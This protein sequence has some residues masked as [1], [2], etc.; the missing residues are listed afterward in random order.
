MLTG[1]PRSARIHA[2]VVDV[3]AAGVAQAAPLVAQLA[4]AADAELHAALEFGDDAS[5]KVRLVRTTQVEARPDLEAPWMRREQRDGVVE[6]LARATDHDDGLLDA[7]LVHRL[8]PRGH[9]LGGL[10]VRMRVDVDDGE[11]R[12][13]HEGLGDAIDGRRTVVLQQQLIRRRGRRG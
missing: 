12:L 4:D 7:H 11:L 5:G 3:H 9:R 13:R 2:R 8:H 10:H 6:S 1:N